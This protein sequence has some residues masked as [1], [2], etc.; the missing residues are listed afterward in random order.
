MPPSQLYKIDGAI[1]VTPKVIMPIRVV[2][3]FGQ[4]YVVQSSACGGIRNNLAVDT[5]AK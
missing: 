2:I 1:S 5:F 4:G 3:A